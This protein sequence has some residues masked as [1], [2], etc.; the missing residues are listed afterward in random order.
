MADDGAMLRL[1]LILFAAQA[2]YQA[3]TASMPLALA[4]AG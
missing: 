3:Y 4:R 2:G 1:A